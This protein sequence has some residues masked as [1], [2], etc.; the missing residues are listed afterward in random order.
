MLG[1]EKWSVANYSVWSEGHL[2]VFCVAAY[3]RGAAFTGGNSGSYT[4]DHTKPDNLQRLISA[5]RK[6][7]AYVRGRIDVLHV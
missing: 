6:E 2:P 4:D 5:D 3:V 7:R 1:V